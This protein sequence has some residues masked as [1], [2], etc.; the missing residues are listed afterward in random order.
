MGGGRAIGGRP[1]LKAAWTGMRL[2]ALN[3]TTI[4]RP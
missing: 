3:P 2:L 4:A 1:W